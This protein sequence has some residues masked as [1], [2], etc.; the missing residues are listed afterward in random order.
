MNKKIISL[1]LALVMVLGTFT[2]VFAEAAK[3]DAKK[4]EV[5]KTE[6][7]KAKA[8]E[9]VEKVV[10]KDNKIQYIVDKKLVEGYE[11]GNLGLDKNI[12]R[13]EITRLLVLANGNEELAKQLQGS[14]KIYSDVDVKHWANGVI[15]VGTTVPSDANGIAMLAGY[16]DGSFKPENDVTY[17]EL[18]KML[19]V[20]AK[21][22]LTADMVKN[23]KWA[24]SW[25][26]WA[27]QL[28]ILDD[29]NVV[30][31]NKAANRADAF[32]M[33]YNALYTMK[34]F[35]RVPA[36]ETRGIVS[37]LTNSKLT[38]NQDSEKEYTITGD[39]VIVD[40][41]NVR[42][43]IVKVN[44]LN[45]L[46]LYKGSLVRILTNDKNEVTHIIQLGNPE[47][48]ARTDKEGELLDTD[49]HIW[50]GVADAT[51]ETNYYKNIESLKDL[52]QKKVDGAYAT[53]TLNGSK[54]KA[55]YIKFHKANGNELANLK[56]NDKT[57]IY[58]ANPYNNIMKEVK[59]INEAL[60]LIGFHNYGKDYKIP[61]VYAGFDTDD[62][63]SA[64]K[65]FNS[66]RSTAKVIVFNVVSKDNDGDRYR[67]I[68][69]SSSKFSSTLEDTDGK[70]YDRD[71][72]LNKANF[73]LNY[74]DLL[75]VIETRGDVIDRLLDHSDEKAFPVVKVAQIFDNDEI[76][77]EDRFGNETLLYVG[78]ADIFNAKQ[79]K[80]LAKGDYLQFTANNKDAR[81]IEIVSI[82]DD[83]KDTRDLFDKSGSVL[84]VVQGIEDH[85]VV[86]VIK[87]VGEDQVEI[88]IESDN[89]DANLN[90][91]TRTYKVDKELAKALKAHV[92]KEVKFKAENK[93][94]DKAV[95]AYNFV[96]N[97]G[98]D[99]PIVKAADNKK[100]T[101]IEIVE[102]LA[103]T[104]EATATEKG[105]VDTDISN[106]TS[107]S[108]SNAL[109][110]RLD[111]ALK[112][113]AEKAVENYVA[114]ALNADFKSTL[115]P[116]EETKATTAIGFAPAAEQAAL[117]AKVNNAKDV[118][119]DYDAVVKATIANVPNGDLTPGQ[120]QTN[121]K[122]AIN[123]TVA[124]KGTV[125]DV[126]LT[127]LPKDNAKYAAGAELK[128]KVTFEKGDA[129][130]AANITATLA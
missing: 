95:R 88:K 8:G 7:K 129:K 33:V 62:H 104:G 70:L 66:E 79:Y 41:I 108:K 86:G 48:L 63:K 1:V 24:T 36:N 45:N 17:A 40:G 9:K 71:N 76:Q 30:D 38:L 90:H 31:S 39:T 54:T 91:T 35:K 61:N 46:D 109:Q 125:K 93:D 15:S 85:T 117:T 127:N 83:T 77:V 124:T 42:K 115:L 69:S 82:L 121:L 12:K 47:V 26:T 75:D 81:D 56:V 29:V 130:M 111:A 94:F 119:A 122:T 59:D 51:V 126:E 98:M 113:N 21:K 53:V 34:E 120:V 2:S 52:D 112:L 5:K 27:A 102:R 23:A 72:V 128:A 4:E 73:P 105:K 100:E 92:G 20:L 22:D 116:A 16:P 118:R 114:K 19:V 13:S 101:A 110:N 107:V 87:W 103:K 67:V 65:S 50:E 68:N 97:D 84:N 58:V 74:G 78:D 11:D 25:M 89:W 60:S 28:G 80:D 57:E 3:A 123:P 6:T 43:Q 49:N 96:L 55:D 37:N 10:G 106:E 14:M 64:V 32:T 18:A 99:T 44:S